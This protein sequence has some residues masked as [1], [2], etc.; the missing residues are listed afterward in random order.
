MQ[1]V[2]ESVK[3]QLMLAAAGADGC[4]I[5]FL[6]AKGGTGTS[7]LC[8]N[9]AMGM[10]KD[11]PKA[12]LAVADMVLPVGS[13]AA[14]V[15]YEGNRNLI[16]A[17]QLPA[18]ETTPDRMHDYLAHMDDWGFDLLAGSPDPEHSNALNVARMDDLVCALR[19][20][21]DFVLFDLGRSLSRFILPIIQ[22][23]D[24]VV[25]IVAAEAC[26]IR[27]SSIVWNYLQRSGVRSP[28]LYAI[29]NRAVGLEGLSKAEVEQQLGVP[30]QVALPHVGSNLSVANNQHQPYV[31][32]FP[33][34]SASI[35]LKDTSRQMLRLAK[36]LHMPA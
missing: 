23:A 2:I 14:F 22:H 27:L 3:R 29:L 33:T 1:V 11:Q 13:I 26:T 34:D 5:V 18:I 7:S 21:Y 4:S 32:Q 20:A 17:A 30:I 36:N 35:M 25:M 19:A 9:L 12:R 8:A 15:G 24:L 6:S 16:T 31:L 28:S 10:A